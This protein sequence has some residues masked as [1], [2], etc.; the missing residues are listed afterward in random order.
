[1]FSPE[2]RRPH[3][4]LSIGSAVAYPV[5]PAG[6]HGIHSRGGLFV[7]PRA[8]LSRARRRPR[9]GRP[10]S[11]L[12]EW[13]GT[14]FEFSVRGRRPCLLARLPSVQVRPCPMLNRTCTEG[15]V[16]YITV[17]TAGA[18]FHNESLVANQVR[19]PSMYYH[20]L[21]LRQARWPGS[22]TDALCAILPS[23]MGLGPRHRRQCIRTALG[24]R[25]Q[26]RL[27]AWRR[28]GRRLDVPVAVGFRTV[29]ATASSESWLQQEAD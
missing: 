28:Q 10:R 8:A 1:M 4:P 15:G 13:Q 26:Q 20:A 25:R 19:R 29:T 2:V 11:Q 22:R 9:G 17:G 16:T 3:L 14:G 7:V 24:V 18:T 27:R 21:R 12:C 23:R 5:S 6:G